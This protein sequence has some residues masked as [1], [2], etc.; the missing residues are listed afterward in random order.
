MA[1]GPRIHLPEPVVGPH[2][3]GHIVKA[4]R[5]GDARAEGDDLQPACEL[6]CAV[7]VRQSDILEC[8]RHDQ[9]AARV[10][11]QQV[12]VEARVG[13]QGVDR[14]DV[15]AVAFFC[16]G[17]IGAITIGTK[18]GATDHIVDHFALAA[19]PSQPAEQEGCAHAFAEDV[20]EPV[21]GDH[22]RHR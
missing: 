5:H 3:V 1:G 11:D 2:D 19:E 15:Q 6:L 13:Q 18:A 21:A 22:G 16:A 20:S 8:L 9:T 10:R 17:G 12:E 4:R 14:I 7:L